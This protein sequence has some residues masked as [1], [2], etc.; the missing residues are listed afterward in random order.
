MTYDFE[1]KYTTVAAEY[2]YNYVNLKYFRCYTYV[3]AGCS[4]VTK[5]ITSYSHYPQLTEATVG[6]V[7]AF[8]MQYAPVGISAGGQLAAFFEIGFGYKGLLNCGL[9]YR[10]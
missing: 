8:N 9:S 3:G 6:H 2:L 1:Y 4:F 10:L 5:I 7:A